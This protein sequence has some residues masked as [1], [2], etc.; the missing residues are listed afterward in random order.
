MNPELQTQTDLLLKAVSHLET[1]MH[2]DA[3]LL[4]MG[5][6]VLLVALIFVMLFRK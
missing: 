2:Q 6:G 3:L 5:T 1:T 4:L